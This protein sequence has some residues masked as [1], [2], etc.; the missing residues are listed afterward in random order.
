LFYH[1]AKRLRVLLLQKCICLVKTLLRI[2]LH[3]S[4]ISFSALLEG[5]LLL[6]S[7]I[8]HYILLLLNILVLLN[9]FLLHSRKS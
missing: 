4:K 6:L 7:I 1:R 2:I 3:S 9:I 5:L 8:L